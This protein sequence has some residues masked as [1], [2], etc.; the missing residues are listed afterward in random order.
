MARKGYPAEFRRR[1]LDLVAAGKTVAEVARLLEVSDQSIYSWRRQ[2]QIDRGELPGLSSAEREELRAAQ[3]A[4][5][6]ARDRAGGAPSGGGAAEG[7]G[8]P[9]RRFEA[10]AVIAGEGLPVE[11]ACRVLDVSCAGFYA[12]RDRP[13]SAR[14]VRHAWLTDVIREVH[15]ASYGSYG[16]KRVHAE[17]DARPRDPGRPQRGR[18]A[19]AAGRDRGPQRR[20]ASGEACRA[21]RPPRTSSTASSV[22]RRPEPALADRHHRAPDPGGQGLLRGRARRVQPPR[23]RLVDQPQPD[24][25]ADLQRA[26][27]GDRATRRRPRRP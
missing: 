12:W 22:A 9:K 15:A 5:P 16:A 21:R 11:V 6:G 8:A 26:R 4:D 20:A 18:D 19:D 3:A 27:D 23:G 17:L 2:E 13:P 25:R 10:I 24:R 7:V 1:A 14:A